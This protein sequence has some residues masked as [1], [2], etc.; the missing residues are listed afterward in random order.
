MLPLYGMATS[1]HGFDPDGSRQVLRLRCPGKPP[2]RSADMALVRHSD[3]FDTALFAG[4][5]G[6][7]VVGD[8][9]NA[10]SHGCDL[11][12]M[13]RLPS[14][15]DYLSEGDILGFEFVSK[16]FRTLY[17]CSSV[18]NSFLV[19]ERCNHYCLM[20]SQPPKDVDDS[21]ILREIRES[22]PLVDKAT[23]TMGFTGGEPLLDWRDFIGVLG[24]AA[25]FYPSPRFTYLATAGHSPRMRWSRPGPMCNI[26]T[27]RSAFPFMRP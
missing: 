15:F 27:L 7:V 25:L 14:K 26:R 12:R 8:V 9:E 17:R 10:L 1:A 23:R 20:C 18:Y 4:F 13:V 2:E 6:A 24:D 5:A 22:L 19:T 3:D 11:P 21:W 16:R